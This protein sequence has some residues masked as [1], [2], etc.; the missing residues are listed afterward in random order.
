MGAKGSLSGPDDTFTR[1]RLDAWNSTARESRVVN[2]GIY[3]L[4]PDL[5]ERVP[6]DMVFN[7]PQLLEDCL[8]RDEAIRSFEIIDDWI[9][10]GQRDQLKQA[11][12][13]SES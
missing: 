7:M 3:V 10:V 8:Q 11:R 5:L 1:F 13:E 9:D 6:M 12:G 4:D 2:T